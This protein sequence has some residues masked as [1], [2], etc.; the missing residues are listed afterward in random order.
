MI[1]LQYI[2]NV[3]Q[4]IKICCITLW[5]TF[6]NLFIIQWL[7]E[8]YIIQLILSYKHITLGISGA[9]VENS[10]LLVSAGVSC[11]NFNQYLTTIIVGSTISFLVDMSFFFIVRRSF[12]RLDYST[13]YPKLS[14]LV[15]KIGI[16]AVLIYRFIPWC[17]I[18]A[19]I[20]AIKLKT[21]KVIIF[22]LLGSFAFQL[23]FV[24]LGYFYCH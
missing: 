20:S 12:T 11:K 22:N 17:R 10:L 13:K 3:F 23:F 5:E 6:T 9:I 19:L 21:K 16:W 1:V 18:P 15:N 4:K 8:T 7:K 2:L 24:S 14:K